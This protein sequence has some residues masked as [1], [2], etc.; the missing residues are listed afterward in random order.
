MTYNSIYKDYFLYHENLHFY[1]QREYFCFSIIY[2]T[3]AVEPRH[4]TW[5][6]GWAK[7]KETQQKTKNTRRT[8]WS[9]HSLYYSHYRD[10][11]T[12]QFCE[13]GPQLPES[14][15]CFKGSQMKGAHV[16]HV[17]LNYITSCVR[18]KRKG[19]EAVTQD[20]KLLLKGD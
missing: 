18:G 1:D 20:K 16:L 11:R 13:E 9:R 4:L 17:I 6:F 7:K 10:R 19:Q 14:Q 5:S 12:W 15:A 8:G 2:V 3:Q